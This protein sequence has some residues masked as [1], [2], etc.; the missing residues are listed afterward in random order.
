MNRNKIIIATILIVGLLL[1][2]F[3]LALGLVLF[4]VQDVLY[5]SDGILS[6]LAFVIAAFIFGSALKKVVSRIKRLWE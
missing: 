3:L 6:L 1:L 2:V 4:F 5:L